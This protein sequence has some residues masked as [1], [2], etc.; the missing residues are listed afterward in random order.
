[1]PG[2]A[3]DTRLLFDRVERSL[4]DFSSE[5]LTFLPAR[6]QL[7]GPRLDGEIR[8]VAE[9]LDGAGIRPGSRVLLAASHPLVMVLVVPA[10]WSL[11]SVPILGERPASPA[12]IR[13]LIRRLGPDLVLGEEAWGK[14]AS[15]PVWVPP[16]PLLH[17]EPARARAR[18]TLPRETVLV[19]TTS[20]TSGPAR[21]V[22]LSAAQL[23]ADGRA[24][25]DSLPLRPE[26]RGLAA[27]P[28]GH[29]YGFSTLLTPLLFH[30]RPLV[31]LE[32][33]LPQ[34]FRAALGRFRSL[35]FPGVPFLYRLLL[36]SGIRSPLL[37][38]LKLCISA[39]APLSSQ[40]A[41]RFHRRTG[42]PVRNFY[43]ATE[44][45]A[46][47][48]DPSR[49]GIRSGNRVGSALAG[50]R[51]RL[52]SGGDRSRRAR[53]R[54]R[55]GRVEVA[56]PA[57]ALGYVEADKRPRRFR[58]R[59]RSADY[60]SLDSR[61]RLHLTGRRDRMIN[62]GGRKVWPEEVEAVLGRAPGIRE[63]VA[64]GIPDRLRGE[65]VA[66]A[67]TGSHRLR[68][69][70]LLDF[71]REHLPG[72]RAPRRLLVLREIPRTPRGKIDFDRLRALLVADR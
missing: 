20:G 71:C 8:R 52:V 42:I 36:E 48:W 58:G 38:R 31:L 17:L 14:E 45:G 47:A 46:I 24:I 27:V 49:S 55:I 61:G 11:R 25:L 35:F 34:I 50:V 10:L 3:D 64:I 44:C 15:R 37:S 1:M 68:T 66:A 56:G 13:A 63:A 39:G 43:G 28:L 33:P 16:L 23:L 2:T 4:R 51:I 12:A 19:R 18:I 60:G 69:P 29:A 41:E 67:V 26:M 32:Q 54:I 6:I 21:G 5:L 57:V 22:A 70:A 9:C 30:A 72:H 65:A 59:F 7:S 53:D 40:T 62:V